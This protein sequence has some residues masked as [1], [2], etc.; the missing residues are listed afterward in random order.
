MEKRKYFG[1]M[2]G[3]VNEEHRKGRTRAYSLFDYGQIMVGKRAY[4]VTPRH[5][6]L[7]LKKGFIR[8]EAK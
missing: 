2:Y 4:K 1:R 6:E 7:W 5:I 3:W 8:E